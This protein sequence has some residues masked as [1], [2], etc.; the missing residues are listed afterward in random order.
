MEFLYNEVTPARKQELGT[1]LNTCTTCSKCVES[2][3]NS[4]FALNDYKVPAFK[5]GPSN[6]S[7]WVPVFRWATAATVFVTIGILIGRTSDRSESELRELQ[8]S[9]ARL[10]QASRQQAGVTP[11]GVALIASQQTAR[12]LEDY[13]R[14]IETQR[15]ID[16]R[17]TALALN[18]LEG[19][20]T[21]IR[22]ELETVAVNT[23]DGLRV[24]HAGLAELALSTRN[25]SFVNPN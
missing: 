3:R 7:Q 19:K 14:S 9:V 13:S 17:T 4:M 10:N 8:A 21:G 5:P 18:S 11:E 15:A 6:A 1:H 16:Q 23:Q 25:S 22:T 20:I 2:W 24:T 12:I